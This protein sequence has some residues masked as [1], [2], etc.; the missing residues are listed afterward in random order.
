MSATT[1]INV[2]GR[3]RGLLLCL[4]GFR[5]VGHHGWGWPD[6]IFSNPYCVAYRYSHADAVRDFARDLLAAEPD[7]LGVGFP[8]MRAHLA[9]L[10]G[11]VL[12][13]HCCEWKP[14]QRIVT[15]CHAIVLAQLCDQPAEVRL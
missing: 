15:P 8:L 11:K 12:G 3:N 6:S 5:Y 10:R 1:V 4:P 9:D 7:P 2:K 13:C 14:G